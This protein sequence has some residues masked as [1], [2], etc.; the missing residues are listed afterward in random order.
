[1]SQDD[2]PMN[3]EQAAHLL[4]GG[5]AVRLR[6]EPD[7]RILFGAWGIA[8]LVGYGALWWTAQ[9]TS[10]QTP[11]ALAFA[12]FAFLLV[13]ASVVTA[14][15]TSRRAAGVRGASAKTGEMYGWSWAVTFLAV[16]VV[17]GS[18]SRFD[19]PPQQFAVIANVIPALLVGALYMAGAATYRETSWFVLGAWIS[20]VGAVA[21]VIDMPTAYLVMALAGGGVMLGVAAWAQISPGR[22]SPSAKRAS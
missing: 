6:L 8:W 11:T 18:L 13:A 17:L 12:L 7:R 4:E 1:M 10:D 5:G 21:T 9:A 14:V 16:S 3:L 2:S 20:A 15:H 19:I 22:P